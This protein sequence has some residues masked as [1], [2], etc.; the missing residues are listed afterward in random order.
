M[1]C[2][3]R[4]PACPAS[5]IA[6]RAPRD[7]RSIA[8]EAR[9]ASYANSLAQLYARLSLAL[10]PAISSM[11]MARYGDALALRIAL[12]IVTITSACRAYMTWQ[13]SKFVVGD[14]RI[15]EAN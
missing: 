12:T 14:W 3:A 2:P 4:V 8:A 11:V 6:T 10:I 7:R 1:L 5:P 9:T 13:L 15:V